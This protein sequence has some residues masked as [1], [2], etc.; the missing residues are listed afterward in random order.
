MFYYTFRFRAMPKLLEQIILRCIQ[1][2]IHR[3]TYE[4]VE[5]FLLEVHAR[6]VYMMNEPDILACFLWYRENML[7]KHI[8]MCLQDDSLLLNIVWCLC[9]PA[10]STAQMQMIQ[11]VMAEFEAKSGEPY[12]MLSKWSAHHLSIKSCLLHVR[13]AYMMWKYPSDEM[14]SFGCYLNNKLDKHV[15]L[16]MQNS[17]LYR[18]VMRCMCCESNSSAHWLAVE[19]VVCYLK[20][21]YGESFVESFVDVE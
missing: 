20:H 12:S 15:E 16:C 4:Q 8:S 13:C 11:T 5:R 3:C 18:L 14:M 10:K 1:M 6:H 2:R 7:H 9:E 21:G 19:I 17:L